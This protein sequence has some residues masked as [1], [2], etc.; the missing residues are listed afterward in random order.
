MCGLASKQILPL[1]LAVL[2]AAC[3]SDPPRDNGNPSG[4]R[5]AGSTMTNPGTDAT[6]NPPG[7]DASMMNP[8][9]DDASMPP[10]SM[11]ASNPTTPDSG[12]H[13]TP[14]ACMPDPTGTGN[15]KN[16]GAYCTNGGE[17]CRQYDFAS[18]CS[19]DLD[20]EGSN[21]CIHIGCR[22][23]DTCGEEACCTGRPG[24]PIHAC[25]PK[26]CLAPDA[27]TACP[28]IP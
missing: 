12:P 6:T 21:F 4:S 9:N 16:V 10:P 11:D 8:S 14:G 23:H 2:A 18:F 15:S 7:A 1:V 24:N 22:D 28:D 5:D 26:Q 13:P 19:I 27:G 3:G 17:Q 20:S 25:V